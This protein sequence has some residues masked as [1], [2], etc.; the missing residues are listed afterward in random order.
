MK[1]IM[2]D[3]ETLGV[4]S[5]S[6]ITTISAVQFDLVTGEIG[7]QFECSVDWQEQVDSGAI[8]NMETIRWWLLQSKEA[9]STM[10]KNSPVG[11][12][13]ACILFNK[14]L[15]SLGLE[16]IKDVSIW[17]NGATFDNVI[18]RN[19][20]HRHKMVFLVPFWGDQDV[21]TLVKLSGVN[22]KE[23]NFDGIKHYGIDD[24]KH[25]IKYCHK[26]FKELRADK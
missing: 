6:V 9:I 14:W 4:D 17:G 15:N 2:L 25:Q 1:D 5:H 3:L 7:S 10:L 11:A 13:E 20:Y 21:R 18:L 26:C 23:I 19:M 24:C 16:N 22:I 8:V 12:V